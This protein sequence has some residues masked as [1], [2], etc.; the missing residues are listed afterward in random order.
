M[1]Q[2][3]MGTRSVMPACCRCFGH[4]P[5]E[6]CLEPP[7]PLL[8]WCCVCE[9]P[10]SDCVT[11]IS[12]F[13]SWLLSL[14][15]LRGQSNRVYESLFFKHSSLEN[16]VGRFWK[17]IIHVCSQQAGNGMSWAQRHHLMCLLGT[18]KAAER[19]QN[20]FRVASPSDIN[21]RLV[22]VLLLSACLSSLNVQFLFLSFF[23]KLDTSLL[24]L[25]GLVFW[26][27]PHEAKF[28]L[29][30]MSQTG[31]ETWALFGRLFVSAVNK[32]LLI[33]DAGPCLSPNKHTPAAV[34]IPC[35]SVDDPTPTVSPLRPIH[36][37]CF[38]LFPQ[39]SLDYPDSVRRSKTDS[40]CSER[41][42]INLN[43]WFQSA[44]VHAVSQPS[45]LSDEESKTCSG[46]P[47]IK[48]LCFL[49]LCKNSHTHWRVFQIS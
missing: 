5:E 11:H 37:F 6:R 44:W 14:C 45:K 36:A 22:A 29:L 18:Q 48:E 40:E 20:H 15:C 38:R 7:P 13:R 2:R 19:Q 8:G 35:I 33:Y 9:H 28:W 24:W 41:T 42:L 4:I 23:F 17:Q 43:N 34:V 1:H 27:I 32:P 26:F 10:E 47:V 30:Q 16:K 12:T 39:R 21:V 25:A 49:R 3:Y 46:L 31:Q